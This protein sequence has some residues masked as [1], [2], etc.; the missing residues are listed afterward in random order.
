MA[1]ACCCANHASTEDPV[2]ASTPTA[3]VGAV[4]NT[5]VRTVVSAIEST[6]MV[7]DSVFVLL[8]SE[9]VAIRVTV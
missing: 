8:P 4:V 9:F 7:W 1:I 6:V 2:V 5:G 3:K